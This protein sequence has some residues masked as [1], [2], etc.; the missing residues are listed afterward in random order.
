ML[1]WDIDNKIN[2]LTLLRLRKGRG[3][4]NFI[5]LVL[6]VF[7]ISLVNTALLSHEYREYFK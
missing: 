3:M 5:M 4:S 6:F 2:I 7:V 1:L